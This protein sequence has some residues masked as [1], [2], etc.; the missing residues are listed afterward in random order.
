MEDSSYLPCQNASENEIE[1][2]SCDQKTIR[3]DERPIYVVSISRMNT[4]A[5]GSS[6]R[7]RSSLFLSSLVK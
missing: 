2:H 7:F 4:K 5:S 1:T 3:C 6:I